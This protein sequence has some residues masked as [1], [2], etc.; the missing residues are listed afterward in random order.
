M[1]GDARVLVHRPDGRATSARQPQQ[2]AAGRRR[3][4]PR[5]DRVQ[6]RLH[7]PVAAHARRGRD[8]QRPHADRGRA[9]RPRLGLRGSRLAARRRL[10]DAPRPPRAPARRC[11]P[12]AVSRCADRAA[13]QAAFAELGHDRQARDVVDRDGPG[14]DPGARRTAPSR[15]R[16]PPRRRQPPPARPAARRITPPGCSARATCSSS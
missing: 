13:D 16:R 2:D 3:R 9:R 1:G 4:L 7:Q 11:P 12:V 6:D 15:P 8:P 10:R 14:F 5:C